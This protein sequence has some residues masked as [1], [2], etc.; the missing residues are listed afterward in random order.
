MQLISVSV[1]PVCRSGND[2]ECS[3]SDFGPPIVVLGLIAV[4]IGTMLLLL[5]SPKSLTSEALVASPFGWCLLA[6]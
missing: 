5:P 6:R 3:F 2:T 1:W 4:L